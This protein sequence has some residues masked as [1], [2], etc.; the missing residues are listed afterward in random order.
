MKL[1]SDKRAYWEF[2]KFL[3]EHTDSGLTVKDA[4]TE[5]AGELEGT[6]WKAPDKGIASKLKKAYKIYIEKYGMSLDELAELSA[7]NLYEAY[8]ELGMAQ[9]KKEAVELIGRLNAGE[10]FNKIRNGEGASKKTKAEQYIKAIAKSANSVNTKDRTNSA[11][12]E[13]LL[14]S[15]QAS[16]TAQRGNSPIAD[17]LFVEFNLK[18]IDLALGS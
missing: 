7:L 8:T 16:I 12:V 15:Y 18:L 2:G 4:L 5:L 13:Q 1:A 11:E 14:Q 17:Q 6:G 9:N 3:S 10:K